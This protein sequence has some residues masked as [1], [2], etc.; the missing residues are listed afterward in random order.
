M[1][2]GSS[3]VG[4]A[5]PMYI[6]WLN[7]LVCPSLVPAQVNMLQKLLSRWCRAQ[8]FGTVATRDW[9]LT[10]CSCAIGRAFTTATVVPPFI[11]VVFVFWQGL[12]T[13]RNQGLP[14][15]AY[16]SPFLAVVCNSSW[17]IKWGW[18]LA[19]RLRWLA[20]VSMGWP[21]TDCSVMATAS[22]GSGD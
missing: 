13:W 11:S 9:S 8:C 14:Y 7:S 2:L 16:G 6:L 10:V 17:D 18:L 1:R 20:P 12:Y 19:R 5:E 15:G 22:S 4:C 3:Q 21:W